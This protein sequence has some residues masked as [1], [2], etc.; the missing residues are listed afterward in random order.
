MITYKIFFLCYSI[1]STVTVT[2]VRDVMRQLKA[3]NTLRARL[4][5]LNAKVPLLYNRTRWSG[6][7]YMLNR[8]LEYAEENTLSHLD[9]DP[10]NGFNEPENINTAYVRRITGVMKEIDIV[11]KTL[12][13][14]GYRLG[15]GRTKVLSLLNTVENHRGR[16]NSIFYECSLGRSYFS[17]ENKPF[18]SGVIKIQ[19]KLEHMMT[20]AEKEACSKLRVVEV[21]NE[22]VEGGNSDEEGRELSLVD[23]EAKRIKLD[24]ERERMRGRGQTEQESQIKYINCDFI[25]C[26]AAEVER[27]WSLAKNII[28]TDRNRMYPIQLEAILFLKLNEELWDIEDVADALLQLKQNNNAGRGNVA[29]GMEEEEDE[30]EH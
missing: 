15:D 19:K 2:R 1:I 4:R 30:Q 22:V 26:S 10:S 5:E 17:L 21:A 27:L 16:R 24:E 28:T 11:T 29:D 7:Y 8:Y 9:E 23:I 13:T 20:E 14:R 6:K 18:E 3:S 25:L 12:Q